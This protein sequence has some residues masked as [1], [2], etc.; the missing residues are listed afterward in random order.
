MQDQAV[1]MPS[2]GPD[3]ASRRRWLF[4]ACF[5]AL[6]ATSC[7]FI[8]RAFIIGDLATEFGLDETQKGEI[9]GV[10]LWPFAI[11]IVLFSL[12]I[13]KVGYGRA[14][15]FAFLCHVVSIIVTVTAKGYWGLYIGTFI[16][17]LGNGTVEAAI[18]PAVATMFPR[19][20]TKWLNILH[21]GWPG[22]M[23][24][25][26]LI[27]LGTNEGGV[28]HA[29]VG[30][31]TPWRCKVGVLLLPV[32]VYGVMMLRC[33]FPVNERVAAGVPYRAM[34]RE[35]GFLGALIASAL[36]V[37]E[38]TR[39]AVN[40][41]WLGQSVTLDDL[42]WWRVGLTV[43]MSLPIAVYT[44]SLGRPLFVFLMLLMIPLAITELSTDAWIKELM[45][46]V[47]RRVFE[48]DGGWVLIYSASIMVVLRLGAGPFVKWLN[49]L[50]MLAIS[51][52]LAAVGL[53]FLS[54]ADGMVIVAAAT[55]Y[56]IGQS[57]FWPTTLGLVSERFPRGGAVTLNTISGVGMLGVGII[58]AALMGNIQDNATDAALRDQAPALHAQVVGPEKLSLFGVYRSLD[59][60]KLEALP[61]AEVETIDAVRA[62]AKK[63]ALVK[64]TVFPLTMLVCYLVLL[65]YFKTRG[66]YRAETLDAPAGA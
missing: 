49:P 11:S 24:L 55:I 46:P 54:V 60:T 16:V 13:D 48:I 5:I 18:N 39:V 65:G 3:P 35:V 25:G 15:F 33:R 26:G 44:R 41:G 61:P 27:L 29:L 59:P 9:L 63:S 17:A 64:V 40:S 45:Q 1:A 7:G 31:P 34:L 28:L 20:K 38:L 52:L 21:A 37:W 42:L 36:I 47:M 22:G 2:V 12:V 14:M 50:G 58:G 30:G 56:G 32:L 66:G 6:V 43:A 53:A 10:G 8:I 19:E 23:I 57:F 4:W 62:D 51:S